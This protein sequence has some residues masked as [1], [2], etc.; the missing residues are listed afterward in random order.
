[1]SRGLERMNQT[2]KRKEK[3]RKIAQQNYE[4][5][6]KEHFSDPTL[7]VQCRICG[8]DVELGLTGGSLMYDQDL[9][10]MEEHL[11]S[12]HD[13][14]EW[15]NYHISYTR[16][17]AEELEPSPAELPYFDHKNNQI[18]GEEFHKLYDRKKRSR[19]LTP[20]ELKEKLKK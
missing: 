2:E 4:N 10:E 9:S 20:T 6:L 11:T 12:E 7:T 8:E 15:H 18:T 1:M 19:R 13:I 14:T 5:W 17:P 16:P 3:H